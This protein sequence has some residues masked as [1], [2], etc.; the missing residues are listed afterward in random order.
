[1]DKLLENFIDYH[2]LPK[3]KQLFKKYDAIEELAL[4]GYDSARVF[5]F[6]C[7]R[8]LQELTQ[9]ERQV[10]TLYFF[11]SYNMD[12]IAKEA[13]ISIGSVHAIIN[14][15]LDIVQAYMINGE[16]EYEM[17]KEYT[18]KDYKNKNKDKIEDYNENKEINR[19][20]RSRDAYEKALRNDAA[21]Q[22]LK[23]NDPKYKDKSRKNN[24]EYPYK[25]VNS[26]FYKASKETPQTA[27][28]KR[29]KWQ[30]GSKYI[31]YSEL[32]LFDDDNN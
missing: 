28:S 26:E 2:D 12:T 15:S 32:D 17:K 14:S 10:F 22:W 3:L 7:Q 29:D 5:I 6:D 21:E 31:D 24:M 13:E 8:G 1:M 23:K 19:M 18:F 9:K 11:R 16:N 4:I 20:K 27:L 30:L 25:T